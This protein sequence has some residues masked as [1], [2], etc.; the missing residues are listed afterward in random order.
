MQIA[1]RHVGAASR[2]RAGTVKPLS[3]ESAESAALSEE[4]QNSLVAIGA[5]SFAMEALDLELE[6][7]GHQLAKSQFVAP[8]G[9]NRGFNVA[10]RLIQVFQLDKKFAV[11]LPGK[12]QDLFELRNQS[13]HFK[14]VWR[15]GTKPHPSGTKTSEELSIFTLERSIEAIR[16]GREVFRECLESVKL[17]YDPEA[18]DVVRELPGVLKMLDQVLTSEGIS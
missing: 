18:T 5:V 13:V 3:F 6:G 10:Q 2:A 12:L 1:A 14:S 9:A 15:G 7:S 8:P 17:R 16:L 11:G 4:F